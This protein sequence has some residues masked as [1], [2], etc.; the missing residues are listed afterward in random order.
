MVCSHLLRLRVIKT[1]VCNFLVVM[2]TE[3][4]VVVTEGRAGRERL[5]LP[6][7][8]WCG[9]LELA[10]VCWLPDDTQTSTSC[11]SDLLGCAE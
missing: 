6:L 7:T 1:P 3:R 10:G 9:R 2:T 11:L 4:K 8:G 5:D